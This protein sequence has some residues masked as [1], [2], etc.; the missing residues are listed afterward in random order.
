[1]HPGPDRSEMLIFE[2]NYDSTRGYRESN[3]S[4]LETSYIYLYTNTIFPC[5]IEA[6]L[7]PRSRP[8]RRRRSNERFSLNADA[9][10]N[11]LAC[12]EDQRRTTS[13]SEIAIQP[14]KAS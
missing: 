3:P 13:P 11:V 12:H 2:D 14:A 9:P 10:P 1:M 5:C 8:E 7:L 6:R 4:I